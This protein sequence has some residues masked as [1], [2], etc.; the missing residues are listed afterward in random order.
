MHWL[1]VGGIVWVVRWRWEQILE[2]GSWAASLIPYMTV[3]YLLTM[4]HL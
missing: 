3:F 1:F 2:A 4:Q